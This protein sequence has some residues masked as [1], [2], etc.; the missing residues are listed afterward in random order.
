MVFEYF[1][2]DNLFAVLAAAIQGNVDCVDYISHSIVLSY[3]P[4][5]VYQN[6]S[7][8]RTVRLSDFPFRLTSVA[9]QLRTRSGALGCR[10]LRGWENPGD[11]PPRLQGRSANRKT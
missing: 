4:A 6:L 7:A 1:F 8:L 11:P 2:I 3:V 10:S 5:L 9:R